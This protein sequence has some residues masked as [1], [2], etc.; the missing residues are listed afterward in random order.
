MANAIIA[1]NIIVYFIMTPLVE[2]LSYFT[3]ITNYNTLPLLCKVFQD[4]SSSV[5]VSTALSSGKR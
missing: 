4:I 1:G 2:F 5:S 3:Q